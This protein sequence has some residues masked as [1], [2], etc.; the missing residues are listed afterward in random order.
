MNTTNCQLKSILLLFLVFV[1]F[2]KGTGQ[3]VYTLKNQNVEVAFDNSGNLVSLK[4]LQ[5]GHN[6][7]TGGPIWRLYFDTQNQKG[8]EIL[9]KN[10]IPDIKLKESQIMITYNSLKTFGIQM[11]IRLSLRIIMEDDWVRFCSEVIN[12]EPHTIIRELQYP[13]VAN[14]QLPAECKLLTTTLGGQIFSD[15]KKQI[16]EVGNNPPYM[17]PSQYFRQMDLKYPSVVSANCFAFPGELQGLYLASHDSLFRDTWHGLRLYPDKNG[18]FTEL[19]VGLYKYPNCTNGQTWSCNANVIEPYMGDW[20]ETS[21]LY[22]KWADTWWRH[23]EPPIWVKN[24]KSWQRIIFRHQYGETFFHYKDL[25]E[26]ILSVGK[27]VEAN[28]V[29]PF[30]WWNSGM[31]NGYPDSYFQT[32]HE[33]GGDVGWKKAIAEFKEKGGKL[34]LYFNGKLIDTESNYYRKDI[35]KLLCCKRNTGMD[36]T[37]AYLFKAHDTFTGSFN[38]RSFVVA[39]LH[40]QEWQKMLLSFADRA[41][42]F[43]ANAVFYDQLGYLYGEQ[44]WDIEKEFPVPNRNGIVD[45]ANALKMIHEYI[46]TKDKNF[47]LGTEGITDITSQH[48]DFIHNLPGAGGPVSFI[49]WY[50][51]TFPEVIISDREIRDDTDVERRVNLTVLK[52]LRNDIEIYRCRELIDKTPIYQ[53]YLAK[54]N[55]LKDK[56][57]TLLLEGTYCDTEGFKLDNTLIDARCFKNGNRMAVVAT[58]SGAQSA[59]GNIIAPG[60]HFIESDI[61]EKGTVKTSADGKQNISLEK[62]GLIVMIFE[63]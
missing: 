26:R 38:A 40:R 33:Q 59:S 27:S 37:E 31:D 20:H 57:N 51:F 29:F 53:N 42:S 44:N 14:C 4:N 50:R 60:Y 54:A 36:Y 10:N 62:N 58:L 47:A 22:R 11:N 45:R 43:G 35:G 56:Y 28:A 8:N 25:P 48:V 7:A 21:R 46:G 30:G 6:Y 17:G 1:F 15:P 18:H 13:L 41:I 12:N 52:G 61:L 5:T 24:M 23:A 55:R 63:K 19:E 49:E 32:D 9:G 34:L 3:K 39:D 16:L 2:L